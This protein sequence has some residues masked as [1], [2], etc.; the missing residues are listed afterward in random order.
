MAMIPGR[1]PGIR[2][3]IWK[4]NC[5]KKLIGLRENPQKTMVF[6]HIFFGGV[7]SSF[8]RLDP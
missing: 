6:A 7:V 1:D 4:Q 5:R 2:P 3:E 8:I